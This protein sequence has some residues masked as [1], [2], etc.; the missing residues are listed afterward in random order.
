MDAKRRGWK[1]EVEVTGNAL[2]VVGNDTL[3]AVVCR[4]G[5]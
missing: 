1:V 2:T 5:V 4:A 3:S